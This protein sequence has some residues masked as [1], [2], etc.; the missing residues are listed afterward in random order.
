MGTSYY[1]LE[2]QLAAIIYLIVVPVDDVENFYTHLCQSVKPFFV[3]Q[4]SS[5]SV[6]R[7]Y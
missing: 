3:F 5:D 4:L 2:I 7:S 1:E 6:I